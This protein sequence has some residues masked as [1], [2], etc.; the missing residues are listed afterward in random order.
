[1]IDAAR[2]DDK[3]NLATD[4]M[5]HIGGTFEIFGYDFL[6]GSYGCFGF[7][8][9]EN[10]YKTIAEAEKASSDDLYDNHISNEP[11]Q[12]ICQSII[13]LAFEPNNRDIQILLRERISNTN[14]IPNKILEE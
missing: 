3:Q 12:K 9:S 7:I 11:W 4:V 2:P 1:M 5:I 14:Y 10:V 8:P 13:N 6:S